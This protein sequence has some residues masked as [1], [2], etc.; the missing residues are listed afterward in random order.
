MQ[1]SQISDEVATT[2]AARSEKFL[3]F[4]VGAEHYGI[5][6]A[7]TREIIRQG[8]ITTVPQMPAHVKGVINLRGRI[9]P[10]IDLRT[11]FGLVAVD[12]NERACIVVVHVTT[13][14]GEARAM[15]LLVDA[16]DEVVSLTAADIEPAPELISGQAT[17]H[18]VGMAKVKGALKTLLDLDLLIAG[19]N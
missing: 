8:A 5:K 11:M 9:I 17:R 18:I 19:R 13:G 10:V 2:A 3:T 1:E 14:R 12:A 6:V 15:G 16:V 7:C 4:L